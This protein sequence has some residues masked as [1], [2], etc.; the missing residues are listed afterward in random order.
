[1]DGVGVALVVYPIFMRIIA[2][3]PPFGPSVAS[4]EM[5]RR[6][7]KS[8]LTV[9]YKLRSAQCTFCAGARPKK[10]TFY[11]HF[12]SNYM[13]FLLPIAFCFVALLSCTP[14]KEAQKVEQIMAIHD[15]A[16]AKMGYLEKLGTELSEKKRTL[17]DTDEA[18]SE[19]EAI[20]NAK[21]ALGKASDGMM[22]WMN[23]YKE[24]G[25]LSKKVNVEAYL[26]EELKKV[27]IVQKDIN[28]S[29]A[30]AE[31]LLGKTK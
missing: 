25:S 29:I 1:V 20:L 9:F 27:T 17:P 24:P 12:C 3:H 21:L 4:Y 13:K 23:E 8:A 10:Q 7:T 5:H 19:Y 15:E 31:K 2:G 22:T 6:S 11:H 16:M 30:D 18:A 28:Q 14:K 26:D